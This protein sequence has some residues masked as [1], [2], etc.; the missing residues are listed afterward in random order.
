MWSRISFFYVNQTFYKPIILL[1]PFDSMDGSK[2]LTSNNTLI[3]WKHSV[4]QW[5]PT[6]TF[7][8]GKNAREIKTALS[9]GCPITEGL[10]EKMGYDVLNYGQLSNVVTITDNWRTHS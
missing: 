5:T 1:Y 7:C 6:S 9:K 10:D 3:S 4:G 8:R 2:A